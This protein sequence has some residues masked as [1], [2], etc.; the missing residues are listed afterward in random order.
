M[1]QAYL[2]G[3]NSY[4]IKPSDASK[5]AELGQ[6]LKGYWFGWNQ[7]PPGSRALRVDH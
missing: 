2:L 6:L 7:L 5:L 3:A 4:V 1:D